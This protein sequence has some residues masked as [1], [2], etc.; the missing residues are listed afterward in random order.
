MDLGTTG[1]IPPGSGTVATTAVPDGLDAD[2]TTT[3]MHM[4]VG[5]TPAEE[6]FITT[7]AMDFTVE[8]LST[9][10]VSSVAVAG[11]TV[12]AVFTEVADSTEADAVKQ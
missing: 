5:A 4:V 9:A 1:A 3:G 2:G 8:K 7:P 12:T 11:S 6:R 10:E